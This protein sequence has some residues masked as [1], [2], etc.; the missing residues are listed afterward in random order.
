MA[1][2]LSWQSEQAP[3]IPETTREMGGTLRRCRVKPKVSGANR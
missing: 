3:I 1:M 2:C